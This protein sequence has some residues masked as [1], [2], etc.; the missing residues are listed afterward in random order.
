M[1]LPVAKI[2]GSKKEGTAHTTLPEAYN[3]ENKMMEESYTVES[4]TATIHYFA[5]NGSQFKVKVTT[6]KITGELV[7]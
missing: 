3:Q 1:V 6:E 2:C 5:L 7:Y 4:S